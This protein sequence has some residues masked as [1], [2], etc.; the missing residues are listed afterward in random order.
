[1]RRAILCQV[2]AL[3]LVGLAAPA[4]AGL[5]HRYLMD[6]GSGTTV[7]DSAGANHGT[8]VNFG[9]GTGSW[10]TG[11]FGGAW[12][13]NTS[14]Y[15]SIPSTGVPVTQGSFVQWFKMSSTAGDWSNTLTTQIVDPDYTPHPMRHEVNTAGV[16]TI[17][18]IPNGA[19]G[20][21]SITSGVTVRNEA[22]HFWVTTFNQAT[23]S[24]VSYIDGV[25]V[26]NTSYNTAGAVINPTWLIGARYEGGGGRCAAVYDNAA[27]YD[28]ALTPFEVHYLYHVAVDGVTLGNGPPLPDH[29]T[30]RHLYT[31]GPGSHPQPN[32]VLDSAAGYDGLVSGGTW[33]SDA[34]PRGQGGWQ[35]TA[36]A[37]YAQLPIQ[38]NVLE[39]TFEGWFK[40]DP[41]TPD[42]ANPFTTSI[43]DINE[44]HSYDA[45]RVEVVPGTTY[46]PRVNVYDIPGVGSFQVNGL[47]LADGEWH[48]LALTYKDGQPVRL[49][50]DGLL[51]GASTANY[52]ASLAY[53]RG[54]TMLGARDVGGVETWRG[55]VGSF[56][57]HGM[58]LPDSIILMHYQTGNLAA[59]PEPASVVLLLAGGLG[60]TA[61]GWRRMPRRAA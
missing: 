24:L 15:I 55:T 2:L 4:Q 43:R 39:G 35:K 58:A 7:T 60:L 13:G 42:W 3:G 49:Y 45:M 32:V 31:F 41:A 20:Y 47:Q 37:G 10:T 17:W 8:V 46:G 38:A 18:G 40:T 50:V 16:G 44:A 6:D 22:W 61:L 33:V 14:G 29:L 21:N 59:I 51:A 23:N 19:S 9:G 30:L 53:D 11:L 25:R 1:M 12:D 57:Y 56:A 27:V 26:G 48:Y 5:V 52:R 34:P 54:Y 28:H 36:A